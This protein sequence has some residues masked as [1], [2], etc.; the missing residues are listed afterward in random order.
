M[1]AKVSTRGYPRGMSQILEATK[2]NAK[3]AARVALGVPVVLFDRVSGRLNARLHLDSY[4]GLAREHGERALDGYGK[5][6]HEVTSGMRSMMH[7]PA[8]RS[9]GP[10]GPAPRSEE[11]LGAAPRNAT[12]PTSTPEP[13]AKAASS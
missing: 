8:P 7:R 4:V 9:E 1:R 11:P 13:R 6:L 12:E 10:L 3:D 2:T 5:Q